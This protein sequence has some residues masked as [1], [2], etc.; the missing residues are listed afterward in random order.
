MLPSYPLHRYHVRNTNDL[1]LDYFEKI[2]H[3]SHDSKFDYLKRLSLDVH[4]ILHVSHQHFYLHVLKFNHC[5]VINRWY[6]YESNMIFR[7]AHAD[8]DMAGTLINYIFPLLLCYSVFNVERKPYLDSCMPTSIYITHMQV[9][10]AQLHQHC[11][12]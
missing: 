10:I 6:L 2:K 8:S 4:Y 1:L 11:H 5:I 7:P 9:S 12:G 3:V